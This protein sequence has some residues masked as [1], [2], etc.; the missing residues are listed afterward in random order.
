MLL[1]DQ[2][3]EFYKE[4]YKLNPKDRFGRMKVT[5]HIR[6]LENNI[7]ENVSVREVEY[8]IK[9]LLQEGYLEQDLYYFRYKTPKKIIKLKFNIHANNNN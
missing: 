9:C 1:K 4:Q 5:L 8:Y 7:Y 6:R 2:I 3:L